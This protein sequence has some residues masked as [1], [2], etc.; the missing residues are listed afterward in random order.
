MLACPP[1]G[2]ADTDVAGADADSLPVRRL[3]RLGARLGASTGP[4]G[5]GQGAGVR[6]EEDAGD[7]RTQQHQ[8]VQSRSVILSI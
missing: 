2:D 6:R 5:D 8:P 7:Q 3:D 4:A 1:P